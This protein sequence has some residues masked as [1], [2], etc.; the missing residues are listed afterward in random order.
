MPGNTTPFPTGVPESFARA[1][2]ATGGPE[3]CANTFAFKWTRVV[4]STGA[5]FCKVVAFTVVTHPAPEQI[6]APCA[7]TGAHPTYP[8][9]AYQ[10]TAPGFQATKLVGGVQK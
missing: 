2:G 1:E 3:V 7:F 4:G 10:L 6:G 8:P 5:P 9:P